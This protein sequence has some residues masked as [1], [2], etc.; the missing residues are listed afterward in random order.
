VL[1]S[2][3]T[4]YGKWSIGGHA[5]SYVTRRARIYER[6]TGSENWCLEVSKV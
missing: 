5:V 4:A 3:A 1:S 2:M 6:A